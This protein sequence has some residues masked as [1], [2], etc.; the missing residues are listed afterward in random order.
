MQDQ[1][2]NR[3]HG[4]VSVQRNGINI[5]VNIFGE[6][7]NFVYYEMQYAIAQFSGD[8]KYMSQAQLEIARAEQA[9]AVTKAAT[10]FKEPAKQPAKA[11]TKPKT[12]SI[13]N[14]P[15]CQECGTDEAMELIR[16][17]DKDTGESK[18]AWKCQACNL[19][20]RKS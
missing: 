19:W 5:R 13:A 17:T 7:R 6:D 9:R 10:P 4:E 15:I 11:F 16:W 3:F 14:K 8:P 20:A 1:Q 2:P 12:T 18:Q